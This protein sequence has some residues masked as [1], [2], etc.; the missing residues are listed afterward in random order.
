MTF[1]LAALGLPVIAWLLGLG[2]AEAQ[3][4]RPLSG[5]VRFDF[6]NLAIP[7]PPGAPGCV[8]H[9]GIDG[10][11][12]VAGARVTAVGVGGTLRIA[13]SRF[14]LRGPGNPHPPQ[15]LGLM[16]QNPVAFQ[17][18]T[19]FTIRFPAPP[20]A[21]LHAGSGIVPPGGAKGRTGPDVVSWC[22]GYTATVQAGINPACGG[23]GYAGVTIHSCPPSPNPC[24]GP[25]KAR[26]VVP[27]LMKYTRTGRMLGGPGSAKLSGKFDIAL[28]A[29]PGAL[30]VPRT[31]ANPP[32]GRAFGAYVQ[33]NPGMGPLRAPVKANACGVIS[34]PGN[35]LL[36]KATSDRTSAS[37]GGPFTQG[38]LTLVVDTGIGI[39][40]YQIKGYDH[41]TAM[42]AGKVRLVAGSVALR[43]R[44][45]STANREY[46]TLD[47]PEPASIAAAVM[48]LAVLAVCHR[49][50][51]HRGE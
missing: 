49:L 8:P 26:F 5:K 20:G 15:V 46:V 12:A 3:V 7:L 44:S 1:R 42:G 14:T 28:A 10:I 9:G 40:Q 41:R 13:G 30:F 34:D 27:G 6:G 17:V 33:H 29:P 22:P 38:T 24:P 2:V 39:E 18:Y 11:A 43:S 25:N 45:G 48:A 37:F 4:V 32:F 19:N 50:M 35:V 16:S 21:T 31:P 47:V 23:P 36:A 51:R